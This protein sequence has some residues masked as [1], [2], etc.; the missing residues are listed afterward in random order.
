MP[1]WIDIPYRIISRV[2]VPIEALRVVGVWDYCVR[3]DEAA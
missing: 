2:R 3:L 1:A